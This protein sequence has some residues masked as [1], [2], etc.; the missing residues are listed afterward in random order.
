[1]EKNG[2]IPKENEL[3]ALSNHLNCL[4]S[5]FFRQSGESQSGYSQIMQDH[6][7]GK[8]SEKLP[9]EEGS[10]IDDYQNDFLTLYETLQ[11]KERTKLM[12]LI[13]D[14]A[15]ERGIEL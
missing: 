3:I 11:P 5:D 7:L 4:V 1:M 12:S 9:L 15:D 2:T 13:Y 10:S 6:P 14:F 8:L